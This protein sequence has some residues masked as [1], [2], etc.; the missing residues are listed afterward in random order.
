L[1]IC[2][3]C[4]GTYWY[5]ITSADVVAP[6]NCLNECKCALLLLIH[7]LLW[8]LRILGFMDSCSCCIRRTYS[9]GRTALTFKILILG[10][11]FFVVSPSYSIMRAIDNFSFRIS[12]IR[13]Y[14]V[15]LRIKSLICSILSMLLVS[16]LNL[17]SNYHTVTRNR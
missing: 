11:S 10:L 2:I 6:I 9:F 13:R 7:V 15:F 16:H 14:Y 12:R 5:Q 17:L 1:L 4:T 3:S 8:C